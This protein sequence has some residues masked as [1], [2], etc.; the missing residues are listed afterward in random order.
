MGVNFIMPRTKNKSKLLELRV[1]K[2]YQLQE[3]LDKVGVKGLS[4]KWNISKSSVYKIINEKNLKLQKYKTVN[5]SLNSKTKTV[6]KV[7]NI[8]AVYWPCYVKN[9]CKKLKCHIYYGT[10]K[11]PYWNPEYC[12]SWGCVKIPTAKYRDNKIYFDNDQYQKF[13]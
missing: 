11:N 13:L 8:V 6:K 2:K 9:I 3:L 1:M 12:L 7:G 5:N 10:T 4:E